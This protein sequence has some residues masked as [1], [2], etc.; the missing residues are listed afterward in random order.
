MCPFVPFQWRYVLHNQ[1]LTEM[2]KN[3]QDF[4]SV[5]GQL[6]FD[7]ITIFLS[8]FLFDFGDVVIGC[9]VSLEVA[10]LL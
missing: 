3:D 2:L 7:V 6:I 1:I 5:I 8:N 4:N 9:V 10:M